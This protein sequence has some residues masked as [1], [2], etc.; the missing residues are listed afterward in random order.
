MVLRV[1]NTHIPF[2][3]FHFT[4]ISVQALAFATRASP[5]PC[6]YAHA[7]VCVGV[8]FCLLYNPTQML[9]FAYLYFYSFLLFHWFAKFTHMVVIWYFHPSSV[10][11]GFSS[12]RL[13]F[14][15]NTSSQLK[16]HNH[17]HA[18]LY[19]SL[20]CMDSFVSFEMNEFKNNKSKYL[21][22]QSAE[23]FGQGLQIKLQGIVSYINIY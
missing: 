3:C 7:C 21:I 20:A 4:R 22:L 12:V 2:R 16:V 1:K 19:P 18:W 13:V 23:K 9:T 6:V 10:F 11:N 8:L 17:F 15:L 14:L 5:H